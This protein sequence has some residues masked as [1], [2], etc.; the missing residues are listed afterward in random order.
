MED[1]RIYQIAL[2]HLAGVGSVRAK[3]LM[4]HFGGLREVF[5]VKHERW[6]E[7]AR[8]GPATLRKVSRSEALKA[9]EEELKFVEKRGL[10]TLFFTDEAYPKRLRHCS[11]SPILLY[12]QG[13]MHLNPERTVAII[14]TRNNTEYGQR[15]TE[16]LI[17][18]LLP[19]QPL[20]ISGLAL[21]IDTIAHRMAL[22]VG[23]PTVAVVGHSLDRV[24][25]PTNTTLAKRM[26]E[27]GGLISEFN[28]GTK[29]DRE[30][31][32]Q[33]NRIVAGM[34]DV[35]I[36]IESGVKGGSL[37][38]AGQALSYHRDV[39]ALPGP[40]DSTASQ[41]CH[42]LIRRNQAALIQSADDLADHMGWVL[43][44]KQPT[45]TRLFEDLSNEEQR[46]VQA[47]QRNNDVGIDDISIA[48][49]LPMSATS[50]T[51]LSLEFKGVVRSLPGKRY[52]LA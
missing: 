17:E 12:T 16:K 20:I 32:P 38:T 11:D 27:N 25:P 43:A 21:G 15:S 8:I 26:Q 35:T 9:A 44:D 1:L 2:K 24:Y 29:P 5:E 4:D 42:Q 28:Q 49:G 19:F 30:N 10:K 18:G 50:N 13:S 48:S 3:A 46:I 40:I 33:R 39:C 36:V 41:G 14:G 47:L 34:A 51:L 31:F 23:L 52:Q 7:V 6:A 22:N 45:Q 37:I